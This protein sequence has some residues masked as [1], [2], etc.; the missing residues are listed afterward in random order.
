VWIALLPLDVASFVMAALV[1]GKPVYWR[2]FPFIPLFG[3]YQSYVMRMSRFY[4]YTSELIFSWSLT[5]N[6]VPQKA[7]D[8]V[9]WR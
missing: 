8:L 9:K 6:Y 3:L 5:D 2:L 1:T 7:R 4:A